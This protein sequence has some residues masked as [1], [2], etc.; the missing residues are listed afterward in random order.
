VPDPARAADDD[1]LAPAEHRLLRVTGFRA[2]A[3]GSDDGEQNETE[4][5]PHDLIVA[6]A[7]P[8]G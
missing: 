4:W 1:R 6:A 7:A 8:P 5:R 3:A 2:P